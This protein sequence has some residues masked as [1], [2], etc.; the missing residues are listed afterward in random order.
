M[1][2]SLLGRCPRS[3]RL[4]IAVSSSSPAVGARCAFAQAGVGTAASQNVTD[5][6][7]GPALLAR[8]AAGDD[9]A[10][11]LATVVA[12]A[13][14]AAFRQLAVLGGSGPGAAVSGSRT[15][16]VHGERVGRDHVAIGNLL[17][18]TDVLDA[19]GEAFTRA[20]DA[21]LLDR[22]LDG[23]AAGLAAGGEA[24]AL[25]SAAVLLVDRF[26]WPLVDLRVDWHD[27]PIARLRSI[28]AVY[29]PQA[30]DYVTR[31]LDPEAAPSYGVAG[32]DDR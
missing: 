14:H 5:P 9:A 3:G 10:S 8:L 26:P 17:A 23:L 13:E 19:T 27:E 11:A 6:R 18:T 22:L 20:P 16:G 7:L 29:G 24:D 25:H 15:L 12:E 21:L 28:A 31:A 1:T 2:F 32:E 30:E 4:G